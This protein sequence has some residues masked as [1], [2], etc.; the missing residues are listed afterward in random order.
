MLFARLLLVLL[1]LSCFA[2]GTLG[3]NKDVKNAA[4]TDPCPHLLTSGV[5]PLLEFFDK[6]GQ[7]MKCCGCPKDHFVLKPCSDGFIS[8]CRSCPPGTELNKTVHGSGLEG[9]TQIPTTV[10]PEEISDDQR[11]NDL[12]KDDDRTQPPQTGQVD[13]K[14]P[15]KDKITKESFTHPG[16]Y[17]LAGVLLSS[18]AL[19]AVIYKRNVRSGPIQKDETEIWSPNQTRLMNWREDNTV[20]VGSEADGQNFEL[21]LEDETTPA[22]GARSS[23]EGVNGSV[24]FESDAINSDE[25]VLDMSEDEEPEATKEK[26]HTKNVKN[27]DEDAT[28]LSTTHEEPE[29]PKDKATPDGDPSAVIR[30]PPV[31]PSVSNSDDLAEDGPTVEGQVPQPIQQRGVA[32]ASNMVGSASRIEHGGGGANT[33]PPIQNMTRNARGVEI[34]RLMQ[35]EDLV[36]HSKTTPVSQNDSVKV[37]SHFQVPENIKKTL[38]NEYKNDNDPLTYLYKALKEI[39]KNSSDITVEILISYWMKNGMREMATY[40]AGEMGITAI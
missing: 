17:F 6:T 39:R 40:V 38:A 36:I 27:D 7:S 15:E 22:L 33:G 3:V 9:C 29:N 37:L 4:I 12:E 23:R 14:P 2:Q 10:P 19:V 28:V 16:Y 11:N 5:R 31:R 21:Q 25:A 26:L 20:S 32:S 34:E 24:G 13:S 30:E 18:V 8:E 1:L 35:L